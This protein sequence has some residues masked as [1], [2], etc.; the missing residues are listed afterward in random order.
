[1]MEKEGRTSGRSI[2]EIEEVVCFGLSR[3]EVFW[4]HFRGSRCSVRSDK[5]SPCDSTAESKDS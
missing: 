2:H 3:S 5:C 4:C 1:M